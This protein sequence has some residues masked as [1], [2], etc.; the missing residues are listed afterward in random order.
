MSFDLLPEDPN[1]ECREAY[2]LVEPLSE[3][4]WLEMRSLYL[5]STEVSALF[6]VNPYITKFELWHNKKNKVIG[7]LEPG[8]RVIWGQRLQDSIAA[9]IAEDKGWDIRRKNEFITLP[10][11]RLAASFDFQILPKGILEVKNVDALIFKQGWLSDGDEIEAPPHIEFQLQTQLLVS[12][13]PFGYIG[14]LIGGNKVEVINR[15]PSPTVFSSIRRA[16]SEFWKSIDDNRCPPPEFPRDSSAVI[17]LYQHAE[18]G[19]AIQATEEI[20]K[21]AAAYS[22]AQKKEASA[23]EIK[24]EMKARL[25]TMIGDVEKVVGDGFSISAGMIGP[26]RIEAYDRK[27]Y[28][29]FRLSTRKK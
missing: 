7:S 15:E 18:P 20:A 11:E 6:G 29:S 21:L 2:G 10:K 23:K 4:R 17:S 13:E 19:K 14:A 25:L 28:R 12:G 5:T 8:E 27:G 3:E 22:E 9:G 26:T 16:A 1:R 24:E